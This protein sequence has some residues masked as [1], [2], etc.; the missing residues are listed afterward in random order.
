MTKQLAQKDLSAQSKIPRYSFDHT[1]ITEN[2]TILVRPCW[3]TRFD[4]LREL[5]FCVLSR[6]PAEY[7]YFKAF[8]RLE[9]QGFKC[10]KNRPSCDVNLTLNQSKID[11]PKLLNWALWHVIVSASSLIIWRKKWSA[12]ILTIG[13]HFDGPRGRHGLLRLCTFC[14]RFFPA[15]PG[16]KFIVFQKWRFLSFFLN[17]PDHFSNWRLI[18]LIWNFLWSREKKRTTSNE[19]YKW[20]KLSRRPWQVLMLTLPY[21]LYM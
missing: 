5:S 17:R 2:C 21:K 10:S 11:S 6:F 15:E 9:S 18:K 19:T 13:S 7:R 1:C 3:R 4:E 14:V 12:P 20:S 16:T 8:F